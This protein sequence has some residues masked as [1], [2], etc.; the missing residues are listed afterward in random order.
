MPPPPGSSLLIAIAVT[1]LF[2]PAC[3]KSDETDTGASRE[4][5][6]AVDLALAREGQGIFR[7]RQQGTVDI[8]CADCHA[9]YEDR[10]QPPDRLLPGHSILGAAG[11]KLAWNGEFRGEAFRRTAAGAAK[12]AVLYQ[13]RA[14]TLDAAL[15]AREADALLAFFHA[16]STGS[17]PSRLQ[18][19]AVTYPGDTA[20]SAETLERLMEPVWKIRGNAERGESVYNRACG[21]CHGPNG[22]ELGPS[23]KTQKRSLAAVPRVIRSG[24]GSMPFFSRDKL[25][26]AEI[27]DIIAFIER[28]G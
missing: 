16:I 13:R 1:I 20:V 2:F 17:E 19:T 24:K 21:Y 5:G 3:R 18:W 12:C 15:S 14:K 7:S 28:N 11:R 23:L 6:P 25:E 10:L 26:D 8:A 4:R 22:L 27:A 9:D